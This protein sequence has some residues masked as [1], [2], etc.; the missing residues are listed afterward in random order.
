MEK[1]VILAISLV[2]S[3][4]FFVSANAIGKDKIEKWVVYYGEALPSDRF[5]DYDLIVFDSRAHPPLRPLQNRGKILL[6]YLS[7]GEAE[8]Y[9]HDFSTIE[10]MG[11]LLEE[12]PEWPDHF[13][14]DMRNRQW[15]KYLIEVKIPGILHR[16]FDGLMLDTIDSALY[17]WEK[18]KIK[19]AGMDQAAIDLIG[20]IRQHY[21]DIKIM[22]NRGFQ[23]LPK[24]APSI[25]MVLA[26]SI[27]VDFKNNSTEAKYFPES[28]TEGV[29]SII[30][31][32]KKVNNDLKVY[33]LDYW[34]IADEAEVKNIYMK[35]RERGY[36]PYVST[37]DLMEEY[38]EPK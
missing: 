18:D 34:P 26:E 5:I 3:A 28:V 23:V 11:A 25:D 8:K 22:V 20:A 12:N 13:V 35:Q 33:S 15:V 37:I 2:L 9:R 6:G 21:P 27:M 14:V 17:L 36:V 7:V 31:G 38:G 29:V 24:V 16:G 19:Y 10:E 32:A 30:T 1:F 4:V